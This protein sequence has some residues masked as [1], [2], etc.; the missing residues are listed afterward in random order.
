MKLT[1]LEAW[2]ELDARVKHR[3]DELTRWR[4]PGAPSLGADAWMSRQAAV[5]I[6]TPFLLTPLITWILY[7]W[8]PQQDWWLYES[9]GVMLLGVAFVANTEYK[10]AQHTDGILSVSPRTGEQE[11]TSLVPRLMEKKPEAT[12]HVKPASSHIVRFETSLSGED[13]VQETN[14][15]VAIQKIRGHR[16]GENIIWDF[17]RVRMIVAEEGAE[18][19]ITATVSVLS[20]DRRL[21]I[22][23]G[24]LEDLERDGHVLRERA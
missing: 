7:P 10:K 9:T 21:R 24:M 20:E 4:P 16:R 12:R 15:D 8:L 11:P 23:L 17:N 1:S 6:A 2:R 14:L 5:A 19:L 13:H 22:A 3:F 18:E